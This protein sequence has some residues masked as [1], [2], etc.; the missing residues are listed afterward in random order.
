MGGIPDVLLVFCG[1][2]AIDGDTAQ[3]GPQLAEKL[4]LPQVTY[5]E[6]VIEA[7]DSSLTLRR[8][9]GD[10]YEVVKASPPLL[11]TIVDTANTPRPP[12]ARRMLKY[13]RAR[14]KTELQKE[15]TE[16]YGKDAKE[17]IESSVK[18]RS[19]DLQ[20]KGLLI[21][22]WDLDDIKADLAWCG[23]SGSPTKVHRI[24]SVVLT[25]TEHKRVEPTPQAIGEL[26]HELIEDHTIG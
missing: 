4:N 18:Q 15:A 21:E 13:K 14:G 19:E 10:G 25:G 24:Q 11:M 7:S 9:L 12:A 23:R 2:Q 22:Q 26:V 16:K 17:D 8:N 5:V 3:V 6:E 1:R 20:A